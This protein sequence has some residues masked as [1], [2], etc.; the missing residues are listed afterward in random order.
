MKGEW[1]G[2]GGG[3]QG[4]FKMVG[5]KGREGG[6]AEINTQARSR[7]E[8]NPVQFF[9]PLQTKGLSGALGT[10]HKNTTNSPE[11]LE[12]KYASTESDDPG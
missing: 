4:M 2:E 9:A 6:G 1:R 7:M 3:A 12:L 11:W 10:E 8:E 5:V